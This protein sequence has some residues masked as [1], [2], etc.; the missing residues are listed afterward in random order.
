MEDILVKS[1][2]PS[3]Q[4]EQYLPS[5]LERA[6][7]AAANAMLLCKN[8]D[9]NFQFE[10]IQLKTISQSTD[11]MSAA[12]LIKNYLTNVVNNIGKMI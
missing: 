3:P 11:V 9:P 5:L 6:E 4:K 1:S 8:S 12:M 2:K 7:H 10:K